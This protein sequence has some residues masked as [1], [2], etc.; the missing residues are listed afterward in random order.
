MYI[1]IDEGA[2]QMSRDSHLQHYSARSGLLIPTELPAP[3]VLLLDLTV[4]SYSVGHRAQSSSGRIHRPAK[5]MGDSTLPCIRSLLLLADGP[6]TIR[7]LLLVVAL[8]GGVLPLA[9]LLLLLLLGELL[10]DL[11]KTIDQPCQKATV[12]TATT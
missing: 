11:Q 12:F 2:I 8:L 5:C 7:V 1:H 9:V 10:V 4:V 6:Q 3:L